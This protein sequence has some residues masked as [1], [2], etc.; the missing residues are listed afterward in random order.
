MGYEGNSGAMVLIS[1]FFNT[2]SG[3]T[4]NMKGLRGERNEMS[5]DVMPKSVSLGVSRKN[6]HKRRACAINSS[7]NCLQMHNKNNNNDNK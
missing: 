3:Q 2:V 5:C 4:L 6:K 1:P 7:I